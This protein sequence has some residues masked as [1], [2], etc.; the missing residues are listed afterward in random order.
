MTKSPFSAEINNE[1]SES[2][3]DSNSYFNYPVIPLCSSVA[4]TT[5]Q[6]QV[7][8]IELEN[9][10]FESK[11]EEFADS[12]ISVQNGILIVKIYP[13]PNNGNFYISINDDLDEVLEIEVY[14][15]ISKLIYKDEMDSS[16]KSIHLTDIDKG[17]Y[18]LRIIKSNKV[19]SKNIIII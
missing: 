17:S 8:Q 14:N 19:I 9:E 15:N 6:S 1:I 3:Y 10:E 7:N 16:I 2:I 4:E 13:N 18:L 11:N 5:S 12:I